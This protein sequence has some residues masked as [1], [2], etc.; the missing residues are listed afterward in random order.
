MSSSLHGRAQTSR[1]ISL[2]R[3]E[4]ERAALVSRRCH[5][6]RLRQEVESLIEHHDAEA[7]LAPVFPAPE[8]EPPEQSRLCHGDVFAGRYRIVELL[9]QRGRQSVVGG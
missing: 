9:E 5:D 3:P 1:K 6:A 7:T 2:A 8:P 4:E